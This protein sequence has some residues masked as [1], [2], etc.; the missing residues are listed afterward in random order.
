VRLVSQLIVLPEFPNLSSLVAEATAPGEASLAL[1]PT[2]LPV[3]VL[4]LGDVAL[5][6]G[7]DGDYP[8]GGSEADLPIWD[9]KVGDF[10]ITDE[11]LRM[12][13]LGTRP[14]PLSP[15]GPMSRGPTPPDPDV[16]TVLARRAFNDQ[17]DLTVEN[18]AGWPNLLPANGWTAGVSALEYLRGWPEAGQIAEAIG[19]LE[20]VP[21]KAASKPDDADCPAASP[22]AALGADASGL[23]S[24]YPRAT[25][26]PPAMAMTAVGA[27]RWV[28]RTLVVLLVGGISWWPPLRLRRGPGRGNQVPRL[29]GSADNEG[30]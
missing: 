25:V 15:D 28:G 21:Q 1:V 10:G 30:D 11:A 22:D 17:C 12:L 3:Q 7:G 26:S 27:I 5:V 6:Q 29:R 4:T 24:L 16:F 14:E 19:K 20:P 8:G 13:D 18:G 9:L 23:A 2:L